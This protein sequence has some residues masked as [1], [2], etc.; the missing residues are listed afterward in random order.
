MAS[1]KLTDGLV[2][3]VTPTRGDTYVWDAALARFGVRVTK[4]GARLYLIQY[5]AKTVAGSPS[6]TRRITI[7]QHD[8]KL[9]NVTKARAEARRL[10]AFVDTGTDPYGDRLAEREAKHQAELATKAAD[11]A[12]ARESFA[13]VAELFIASKATKNRTWTETE[14]LLRFGLEPTTPKRPSGHKTRRDAAPGPIKAWGSRHIADIRRSDVTALLENIAKR[15]PAVSRATFTALRPLFKW[16]IERELI[17]LSPCDQI[18]APARPQARD[19]VLADSEL[20][21]IWKASEALGYPF[22]PVVQLLMLTGQRRSEVGGMLWPE[23][24]L[25]AAI[26]RIPAERTKNSK[27][28]E[29]DLSPQAVA[30]LRKIKQSGDHV[31]PARGEGAVRGF[32]AT[33]RRLD[34]LT[35]ELAK[36]GDDTAPMPWRLHDLRRTAATGMAALAFPPHVVERVLNHV[37]GSQGG[38]VGVYQ[39]HEYRAEREAALKAWGLHV[40]KVVRELRVLDRSEA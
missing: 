30:V 25:E 20:R 1:I 24:D 37:S 10:L 11:E 23:V 34:E 39:R 6:K 32:S 38:L 4:A 31:F 22:G 8:G 29:V 27:A 3:G 40:A 18:T 9:W 16:C 26:W 13:A 21:T 14:R 28:H 7:G 19:R 36:Q 5:R 12:R 15:S 33:K 2:E 17:E 35:V